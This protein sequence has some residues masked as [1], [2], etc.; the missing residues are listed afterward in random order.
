MAIINSHIDRKRGKATNLGCP[1]QWTIYNSVGPDSG[2]DL[3]LIVVAAA[4][5]LASGGTLDATIAAQP[6][7]PRTLKYSV[8]V[9]ADSDVVLAFN[10]KG[11]NFWGENAQ[12]NVTGVTKAAP[13]IGTVVFRSVASIVVT[14]KSPAAID[15]ADRFTVGVSPRLGLP[16]KIRHYTD[17]WS[18]KQGEIEGGSGAA[19][20]ALAALTRQA[21]YASLATTEYYLDPVNWWFEPHADQNSNGVLDYVIEGMSTYGIQWTNPAWNV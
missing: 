7:V 6:D 8:S 3:D 11:V 10:V 9:D 12:E 16:F 20:D 18:I 14:T 19:V 1:F 2:Y 5:A 17:I 13:V 4:P 15:A 21:V